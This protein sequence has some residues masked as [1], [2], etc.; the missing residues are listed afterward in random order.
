MSIF[1]RVLVVFLCFSAIGSPVFAQEGDARVTQYPQSFFQNS[2]PASAF[3]MISRLSDFTFNAGSGVRGFAGS[4]GNVLIDDAIVST[5]SLT[6]EDTLRRIPAANVERIDVIRGGARGI[7]MQGFPVVANVIRKSTSE[8]TGALQTILT[9]D[10]DDRQSASN[11]A[12]ISYRTDN[13]L[14]S[15]SVDSF[16][17]NIVGTRGLRARYNSAGALADSGPYLGSG[18]QQNYGITALAEYR[19]ADLGR[20][21]LNASARSSKLASETR[22]ILTNATGTTAINSSPSLERNNTYEFGAD[23]EL[24]IG[25]ITAKV[26]GLY[27]RN[28]P[29]ASSSNLALASVSGNK[30]PNGE[31]IGRAAL[32]YEYADWLT[33]EAG[34]E[35]ALNYR[36]AKTF[37]TIGG[38][39]QILPNANVRV[40]ENRSEYFG[41]AN[42]T[43]LPTLRAELG[44]RYETSVIRQRGDTNNSRE[45]SYLK[46]RAILVYDL[47]P[48]TQ[49][50][51]SAER[52]VGQLQFGSFSAYSDLL[53]NT[54]T[55]GNANLE[56]DRTWQYDATIEQRFWEGGAVSLSYQR[57]DIQKLVDRVVIVTPTRIFDAPG[58]IGNGTRDKI[59]LIG[60]LP[61][62]RLG[63][64]NLRFKADANWNWSELTDPVTGQRRG[65][66]GQTSFYVEYSLIQDVPAWNSTFG[67]T[68]NFEPRYLNYILNELRVEKVQ[69]RSSIYWNWKPTPDL[70][71]S[72]N[73][74]LAIFKREK[75]IYRTLYG[76][77]RAVG[78]FSGS[79]VQRNTNPAQLIVTLRK[80]F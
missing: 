21:R 1:R 18:L 75:F 50:R 22:Y 27:R 5:R 29:V 72:A 13:L 9:G 30:A 47:S 26:L 4:A 12:E 73:L 37:L 78:D 42:L 74:S 20:L 36:D 23:Y 69:P 17:G 44:L 51:L 63:L 15:G 79:E 65:V 2:N 25:P 77:S 59:S 58:N 34:G 6:L 19:D 76:T 64:E 53:L 10:A 14:L 68:G 52:R 40:D 24:G 62:D 11:R 28:Y 61:F 70:Q 54:V 39:A 80:T 55:A 16:T 35:T 49:I 7:D 33:L 41:T 31:T 57:R 3:D 71:L 45:F 66:S 46:P 43:L 56:P 32:R 8:T 67:L 48:N 60:T 38:V